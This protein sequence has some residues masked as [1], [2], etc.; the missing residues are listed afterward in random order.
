MNDLPEGLAKPARRTLAGGY[1]LG[2][3]AQMPEAE[4]LRLRGMGPKE[5]EQL[6][7]AL[8]ARGE[9]FAFAGEERR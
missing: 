2:H 6:R 3:L 8:A 5:L 1:D 7:L 4:A 9:S